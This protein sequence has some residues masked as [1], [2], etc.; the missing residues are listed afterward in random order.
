MR[1]L[2]DENIDKPVVER[3]RKEGHEVAYILEMKRGIG[4]AEIIQ[5]ANDAQA[6][7]LTSDKD[8]GELV[9][10][11]GSV[12]HGVLLIRLAGLSPRRKAEV[13]AGGVRAHEKE[14]A[15]NFTV[16]TAGAVRIRTWETRNR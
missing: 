1:L 12:H 16:I 11:Q 3:L 6:V 4:D 5:R 8:F 13:V 15:G 9:F 10:R 7:L 14:L 2:A